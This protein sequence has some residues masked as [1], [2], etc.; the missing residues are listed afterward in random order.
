MS[1]TGGSEEVEAL[2][3]KVMTTDALAMG[4]RQGQGQGEGRGCTETGFLSQAQRMVGGWTNP[5]PRG[6]RGV[7]FMLSRAPWGRRK[8]LLP[9]GAWQGV[10]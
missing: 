4:Q 10:K 8:S 6:A 9:G 2:A 1:G 5:R 7:L 3:F